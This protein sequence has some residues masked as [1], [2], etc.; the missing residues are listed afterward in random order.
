MNVE[1]VSLVNLGKPGKQM[2]YLTRY[3]IEDEIEEFQMIHISRREMVKRVL[4]ITGSMPATASILLAAGC[5]AG[6]R[7][8][9]GECGGVGGGIDG[10]GCGRLVN[11]GGHGD[12]CGLAECG[13]GC[14]DDRR[15]A[16]P[17][18]CGNSGLAHGRLA[19]RRV[20]GGDA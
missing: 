12:A 7:L 3:L 4:I 20:P 2:D 17:P 15:L 1:E 13:C 9:F 18:R 10:T 16:D 8:R 5:G 19:R 14:A 11:G 6:F